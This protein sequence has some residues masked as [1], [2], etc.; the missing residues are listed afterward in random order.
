M[1]PDAADARAALRAILWL[2]VAAVLAVGGAGLIAAMSHP[3]GS[4]ARA[5]LTWAGD[6]AR[7]SGLDRTADQLGD[8]VDDVERSAD[9]EEPRSRRS[10]AATRHAARRSSRAAGAGRATIDTETRDLRS[11]LARPAR[12]RPARRSTTA[13]RPS[14]GGAPIL[15]ALEA[16][17]SLAR[18][19][20]VTGGAAD[21]GPA[22]DAWS[23]T[24][25]STVRPRRRRAGDDQYAA[26]RRRSTGRR[27]RRSAGQAAPGRA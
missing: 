26:A 22:D 18:L 15:A 1:P 13:T 27:S 21:G 10:P 11:A 17:A 14:S 5:E 24:T 6:A 8:L 25:R 19:W 16:A 3:P 7:P 9:A 20:Q 2:L 4:R 12:R 23:T